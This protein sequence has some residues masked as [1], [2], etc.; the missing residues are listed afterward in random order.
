MELLRGMCVPPKAKIYNKD[1]NITNVPI[2]HRNLGGNEC[3]GDD[4]LYIK[5]EM[6]HLDFTQESLRDTCTADIIDRNRF[7]V[8]KIVH[9]VFGMKPDFGGF[10]FQFFNY[11][12]IKMAH[13]AIKPDKIMLHYK[14]EP[15][16]PYW[17]RVKRLVELVEIEK[18]PDQ[19]FGNPVN[20]VAHKADV[21]RMQVMMKYGGIY[22][23]SDVFA[24]R[25]FDPLLHHPMVMGKEVDYGLC[26]AIMISAP[27]STFIRAWYESYR[28]F[29]DS[30]WND[31]S[32]SMPIKLAK[33]MP[34][35]I[36]ALPRTH[37][38]YPTYESNHIKFIHEED[39][40]IFDNGYQ[41]AY[42][43][44]NHVARA[45]LKDLSP[46]T[47]RTTNTSFTRLL[48]KFLDDDLV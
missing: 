26:N 3:E 10:P 18:V 24:Y 38:F 20:D 1:D 4:D 9:F 7:Q 37:M 25:S 47:I 32:V 48:R 19:I 33:K 43:A 16:G 27:N 5:Y 34:K 6:E 36:C 42:H 13:D 21:V 15:Y 17:D 46:T 30:S 8:P 22:L 14:Y 35:E 11:M 40:Y 29:D 12:A 39:E 23:D 31:H 28:T 44:W 2:E 45:Y 41:Y